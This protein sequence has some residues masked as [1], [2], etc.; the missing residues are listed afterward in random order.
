MSSLQVRTERSKNERVKMFI[1]WG[2]SKEVDPELG[3]DVVNC[4]EFRTMKQAEDA[5]AAA[6]LEL[7]EVET[8]WRSIT[9]PLKDQYAY[10][11]I[12]AFNGTIMK[13]AGIITADNESIIRDKSS[14]AQE[15]YLAGYIVL[16]DHYGD[17]IYA[18]THKRYEGF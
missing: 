18:D 5:V 11:P 9:E 3:A 6:G 12:A 2:Y 16:D 1:G 4:G 14:K 10:R 8:E 13:C 7:A 17:R 15:N